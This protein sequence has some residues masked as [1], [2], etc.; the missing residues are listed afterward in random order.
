MVACMDLQIVNYQD[1]N[2]EEKI[3]F[4][5]ND[6]TLDEVKDLEK[7]DNNKETVR[8]KEKEEKIEKMV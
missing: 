6:G 3:G 8:E 1:E 5:C 2:D 4:K 7:L